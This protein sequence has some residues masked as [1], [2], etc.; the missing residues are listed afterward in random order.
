MR[1]ETNLANYDW[2]KKY[3]KAFVLSYD[4][5]VYQDIR[6]V[7]ILNQY[8][9]KCTFN[10]NSGLMNPPYVWEA[11]GVKIERM[12]PDMLPEIYKGHEIASHTVKHADLTQMT[13]GEIF[14]DV[15]Q[16]IC[17]LEKLFG[18]KIQGFAYPFGSTDK[19]VK[20]LL[21]MCGISYARGIQSTHSFEPPRDLLDISPT[22]RHKEDEIFD[23][24][25]QF[26][27][28]QPDTPKI[29][30]LWGHSYE[31]DMQHGWERFER[32][33]EMIAGH[34]DIFYG[35]MGQSFLTE[36]VQ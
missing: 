34:D 32:F 7:Q 10:L 1:R 31:F 35:T 13:D 8:G 27:H 2:T 29:F 18:Q 11:D 26:V 22:C 15:R 9:L 25:E 12:T 21:A 6:L 23:L 28:W 36:P 30:L 4:D 33:C 17:A 20:K 19:R 5:G 24:A 14:D 3:R 16:D